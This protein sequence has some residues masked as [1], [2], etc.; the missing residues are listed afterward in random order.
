LVKKEPKGEDKYRLINT[1]MEINKVTIKDANLPPS[2]DK[3]IKEFAD[4]LIGSFIDFF[5]GYN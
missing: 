2:T 3:F 1:A 5:L 4:I